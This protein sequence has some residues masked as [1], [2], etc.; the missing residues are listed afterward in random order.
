MITEAQ[1]NELIE[2]GLEGTD[3]FLAA[4]KIRTGNRIM[5][6][7]DGDTPVAI[8]DCVK[9]SRFIE[10]NLDREQEDY[11]LQVSSSGADQ[12]LKW[13]RQYPKHTGRTLIVK[14]ETGDLKGTL[15]GCDQNGIWLL[16]P[17]NKKKKTA[18]EK[19]FIA[20]SDILESKIELTFK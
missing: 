11:E 6:F 17:A 8:E 20:F 2:Q 5:V 7:V 1:L 4:L 10:A 3:K 16:I 9:L 14:T 15:E 19:V 18:E 12:P 13:P